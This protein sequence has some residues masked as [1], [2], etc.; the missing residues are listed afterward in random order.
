METKKFIAGGLLMG[1]CLAMTI[2]TG[3]AVQAASPA[4]PVSAGDC[5]DLTRAQNSKQ[6]LPSNVSPISCELPHTFEVS[7]VIT[8]P[9]KYAKKGA[10]S[11]TA[12]AWSVLACE[13]ANQSYM[14]SSGV[15]VSMENLNFQLNKMMPSRAQWAAGARWVVCGGTSNSWNNAAV[16]PIVGHAYG[17]TPREYHARWDKKAKL[18]R[19]IANCNTSACRTGAAPISI[20]YPVT[21]NAKFPGTRAVTRRAKKL[22]LKRYGVAHGW[23]GPMTAKQW[24]SGFRSIRPMV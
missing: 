13:R 5:M 7:K 23:R 15:D 3:P 20:G 12:N 17:L 19:A 4:S 8:M 9:A 18:W 1:S 24:D 22:V 21:Q 2:T 16:V 14:A 10:S 11:R 6:S